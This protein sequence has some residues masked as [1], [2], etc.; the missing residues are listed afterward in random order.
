LRRVSR[1]GDIAREVEAA[2][3]H[4]PSLNLEVAP[5]ALTLAG[6]DCAATG[7]GSVPRLCVGNLLR[8][9]APGAG[10]RDVEL[11]VGAREVA[12]FRR[13]WGGVRRS[14]CRTMLGQFTSWVWTVDDLAPAHGAPLWP[15]RR[16]RAGLT[17]LRV[18]AL[19][20]SSRGCRGVSGQSSSGRSLCDHRFG[21]PPAGGRLFGRARRAGAFV[22]G[23]LSSPHRQA[24]AGSPPVRLA[25]APARDRHANP[26]DVRV[27]GLPRAIPL[28]RVCRAVAADAVS[29]GRHA[30]S[31]TRMDDDG[32][33]GQQRDG[34][35]ES[36][37]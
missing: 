37:P 11:G 13:G 25:Q 9:A 33:H 6:R 12:P 15:E 29:D 10:A 28:S 7:R 18:P 32:A 14:R 4:E 16:L 23:S 31:E 22:L 21:P 20:R 3:G 30:G 19:A 1:S 24:G 26:S 8:E 36:G 34:P 27:T 35:A 2:G 17:R 5:I